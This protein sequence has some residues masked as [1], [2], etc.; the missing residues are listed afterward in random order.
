[1]ADGAVGCSQYACNKTVGDGER[2]WL[3]GGRFLLPEE[4]PRVAGAE[5]RARGA[6]VTARVRREEGSSRVGLSV[7]G[8]E[9][10]VRTKPVR[11]GFAESR[12]VATC[13]WALFKYSELTAIVMATLRNAI[14]S[15]VTGIVMVEKIEALS[16]D[17]RSK[18][19]KVT[20]EV[21]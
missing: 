6:E 19:H 16:A 1:M 9:G 2:C 10:S 13:A 20:E 17:S 3:S 4:S 15:F 5:F 11:V 18:K 7:P 14:S 12:S 8:G 21:W